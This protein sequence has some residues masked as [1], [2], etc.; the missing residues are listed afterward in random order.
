MCSDGEKAKAKRKKEEKQP[1]QGFWEGAEFELNVKVSNPRRSL[2][3]LML[4]GYFTMFSI[5]NRKL[6]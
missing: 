1:C 5:R 6:L 2:I 3:I 4:I